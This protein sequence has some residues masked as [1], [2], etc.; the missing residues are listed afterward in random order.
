MFVFVGPAGERGVSGRAGSEGKAAER[1][2]R[3]LQRT[4]QQRESATAL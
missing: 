1:G 4:R 3:S 2:A